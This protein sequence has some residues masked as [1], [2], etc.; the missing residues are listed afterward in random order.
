MSPL[1]KLF[2]STPNLPS[3]SKVVQELINSLEDEDADIAKLVAQVR[4]DQSLSARVLRLANSSYYGAKHTIGAIDEAVAM[5]GLNALRTLV[6][7]SGIT[8][9]FVKIDGV[10][11]TSFWKHSMFTAAIARRLGKRV[12]VN[13]EFAY[14][15]GLMHRLGQLLIHMAFPQAGKEIFTL[16]QDLSVTERAAIERAKLGLD[17]CEVGA[18]LAKRWH[19]PGGIR[20]ALR[21]YAHPEDVEACPYAA[22]VYLA[23]GIAYGL[24]AGLSPADTVARLPGHVAERVVL[25]VEFLLQEAE[26]AQAMQVEAGAMA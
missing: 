23:A 19:F 5:I 18:E 21:W 15:A 16:C 3:M 7:A 2:S 9:S 12:G 6:I 1:E 25:D 17:H 14:T 20:N 13:A 8:G 22:V 10:D 26:I 11:L 24:E 4:Q